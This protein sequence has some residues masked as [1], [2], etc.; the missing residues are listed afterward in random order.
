MQLDGIPYIIP[1]GTLYV[2][3]WNC[4]RRGMDKLNSLRRGWMIFIIK[5]NSRDHEFVK[6]D[7]EGHK[8]KE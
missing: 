1:E 6:Q 2:L 5:R 3:T 8:E 4:T 7:R